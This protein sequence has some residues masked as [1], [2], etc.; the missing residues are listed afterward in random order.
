MY[1]D[2]IRVRSGQSALYPLKYRLVLCLAA[3]ILMT[4]LVS[5]G[6]IDFMQDSYRSCVDGILSRIYSPYTIYPRVNGEGMI[7]GRI[8]VADLTYGKRLARKDAL[9]Y[10]VVLTSDDDNPGGCF[11]LK[12]EYRC[13]LDRDGYF[14]LPNIPICGQYRLEK[15]IRLPSKRQG[16]REYP[17]EG[18]AESSSFDEFRWEDPILILG[19]YRCIGGSLK[20]SGGWIERKA[21]LKALSKR[22]EGKE[23]LCERSLKALKDGVKLRE[24]AAPIEPVSSVDRIGGEVEIPEQGIGQSAAAVDTIGEE[25]EIPEQGIG[26]SAAAVDTI[27]EEVE[28]PEQLVDQ[29]VAAIDTVVDG[30][31][32]NGAVEVDAGGPAANNY[33]VDSEP[34][35]ELVCCSAYHNNSELGFSPHFCREDSS[36]KTL[37]GMDTSELESAGIES[38]QYYNLYIVCDGKQIQIIFSGFRDQF[39]MYELINCEVGSICKE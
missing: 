17:L 14:F 1:I 30:G 32:V 13:R 15:L 3:V 19:S 22:K 20:E 26:Q 29:Q 39:V 38:D 7:A 36:G 37:L 16:R 9:R 23:W 18:Q 11:H 24:L 27:G 28:I 25:V 12:R 6:V 10:L 35:E 5:A 4:D 31:N 33:F 21:F 8:I 34:W 2:S